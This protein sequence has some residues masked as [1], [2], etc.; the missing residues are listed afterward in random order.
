[1]KKSHAYHKIGMAGKSGALIITVILLILFRENLQA[2][3]MINKSSL[4]EFTDHLSRS[5]PVLMKMYRIPGV[6]VAIVSEGNCRWVSS[7]GYARPGKIMTTDACCRVESI[8]KSVT[9]WGVMKLAE[10]GLIALDTPVC[11]Y[12]RHWKFPKTIAS[13][14]KIT[15]RQLLS[16]C[17]GLSYVVLILRKNARTER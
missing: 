10:Q 14:E 4:Q 12:I 9:A 1:M 7:W 2:R 15:V 8:S 5:I 3:S 11:N 16:H 13:P 17:S 6:S